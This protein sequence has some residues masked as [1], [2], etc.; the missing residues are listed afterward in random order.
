MRDAAALNKRCPA[1]GRVLRGDSLRCGYCLTEVRDVPAD[2]A[3]PA[4]AAGVE[5]GP[6]RRLATS[7]WRRVRAAPRWLLLLTAAVLVVGGWYAYQSLKPERTLALPASTARTLPR[8]PEVWAAPAGDA[9]NT[10]ST[11]ARLDVSGATVAW[12]TD[13]GVTVS[14]EPVADAEHLY[15]ATVDNRVLALRLS[16]GSPVWSFEAPV[17]IGDSPLVDAGRVIVTTRRGDVVSLDAATGAVVWESRLATNF[18]NAASLSDG[19]VYAFGA[20]REVFGLAA[21]DGASLWTIGTGSDWATEPALILPRS[22]VVATSDRV[23]LYDRVHGSLTLEYPH[24]RVI[25]LAHADDHVISVSANFIAAVDPSAKL[26]WWWGA[27]GVW[28]DLWV[29]GL[30]PEP[31]RAGLRWLH[32]LRPTARGPQT[33]IPEVFPPA[34]GG[35]LAVVATDQGVARAF[36][37]RSGEERW[38]I[39]TD[40]VTGPPVIT[41]DGLVLPVR[42]GLA[43]HAL[44]DG[45]ERARLALSASSRRSLV[46]TSNGAFLVDRQGRITGVR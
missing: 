3:A 7:G 34:L 23:K 36:D 35:G 28:F 45:T 30:A 12:Q 24:G 6:A 32:D 37:V 39:E 13:L 27:R 8:G 18:Y 44:E 33:S 20:R 19:V 9:G 4:V 17:P 22:V 21:E 15:V 41:P 29:W 25:G 46:V 5:P 14:G 43:L 16:D 42:D 26:P 10:R 2:A 1:C 38:R 11:A 31:P 40:A